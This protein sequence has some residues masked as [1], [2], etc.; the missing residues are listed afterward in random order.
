MR[1]ASDA[2]PRHIGLLNRHE[3]QTCKDFDQVIFPVDAINC[4]NFLQIV[5]LQSVNEF[6]FDLSFAVSPFALC[7]CS[8]IY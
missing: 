6:E 7:S 4:A 1:G 2:H 8:A 3:G 5:L